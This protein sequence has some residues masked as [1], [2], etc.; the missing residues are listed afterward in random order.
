MRLVDHHHVV[1]QSGEQL[2]LL[3]PSRRRYRGDHARL[4]PEG[5]GVAAQ[6]RVVAGGTVDAELARHFVAPLP[7]QRGRGKNKDTFGHA[8]QDVFLQHHPGLDGLAEPDLVG[9]QHA[10]AVLL[11]HLADGFDLVPVRLHALQRRQAKQFVESLEQA[12]PD[13]FAAQEECR[14]ICTRISTDNVDRV[15]IDEL[16]CNLKPC[17]QPCQIRHCRQRRANSAIM[18]R[19]AVWARR[20]VGRRTG[21]WLLGAAVDG[22]RMAGSTQLL[23]PDLAQSAV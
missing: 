16:E 23:N 12:Q 11:Q 17:L 10:T 2:G 20:A 5:R 4:R 8:A 7:D 3:P 18:P 13:E 19:V 14:G 22:R 21:G 1:T 9:Q 6:Q 15:G